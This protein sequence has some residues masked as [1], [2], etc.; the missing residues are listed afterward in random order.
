MTRSLIHADLIAENVII[1]GDRAYIV[2]WEYAGLGDP[3]VDLAQVV[4]LF[5]LDE[6]QAALLLDRHG[7][8]DPITVRALR[9]TLAAREV[10]WCE[11]QAY[12][13]GIQGD[14][15]EYRALCWTLFDAV[16]A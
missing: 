11:A 8:V 12:H 13:V 3:A 16:T 6:R 9:P 15:A 1:Q 4:V 10:L 2:D 5:E 7:G 14:L